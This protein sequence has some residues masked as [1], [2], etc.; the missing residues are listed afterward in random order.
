[1]H[2]T[3]GMETVHIIMKLPTTVTRLVRMETRSVDRLVHTT[4]IS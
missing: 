3:K 2:A 1:M 4:S